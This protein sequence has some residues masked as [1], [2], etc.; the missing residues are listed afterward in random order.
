MTFY[1]CFGNSLFVYISYLQ[2]SRKGVCIRVTT[3]MLPVK[4]IFISCL[5][6][7]T[8]STCGCLGIDTMLGIDVVDFYRPNSL[9]P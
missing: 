2:S 7:L 5:S 1:S 3:N 6:F 9:I 4:V 8:S